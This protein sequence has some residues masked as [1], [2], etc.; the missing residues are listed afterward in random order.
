MY[1]LKWSIFFVSAFPTFFG[2]KCSFW[3]AFLGGTPVFLRERCTFSFIFFHFRSF[4]FIFVHFLSFSFIFFHFRSFSFIFV[5]FLACSCICFHFHFLF[6]FLSCCSFFS[7]VLKILFFL[8]RLPHDF[9]LKLLCE[10]SFFGPSRWVPHWALFFFFC[11]IFHFFSFSFSFS[12]SFHVFFFFSKNVSSLFILFLFFLFSGAQN[13][14]RH[15]RIPFGKVHFL[16]WLYLL[17]IG[18]SSLFPV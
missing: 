15:S 10:K 7:R 6:L 8:P 14:W 5:H 16:S 3:S 1:I 12:I 11:L 13:L 9:L 17:C 18:S 2:G 4:S